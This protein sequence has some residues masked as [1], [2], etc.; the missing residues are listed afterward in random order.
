M[1]K[2]KL[3]NKKLR[4]ATPMF[5]PLFG[6]A[7]ASPQRSVPMSAAA[8]GLNGGKAVLPAGF[9]SCGGS[10][11]A[12][13]ASASIPAAAAASAPLGSF[14]LSCRSSAVSF[15]REE[16][17]PCACPPPLPPRLSI[18]V[19]VLRACSRA[20]P[21]R[22]QT[23]GEEARKRGTCGD[24]PQRNYFAPRV[25]VYLTCERLPVPAFD[26]HPPLRPSEVPAD[27]GTRRLHCGG[28]VSTLTRR[29]WF[30]SRRALL[31]PVWTPPTETGFM[32]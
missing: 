22:P 17:A 11:E 7:A 16:A 25:F 15:R 27:P 6:P 13:G 28:A 26:L 31:V 5:L 19:R 12:H 20:R 8:P 9:W 23:S 32:A 10:E 29:S 24:P 14:T 3:N 18:V 1:T 21:R 4:S 2:E 30:K